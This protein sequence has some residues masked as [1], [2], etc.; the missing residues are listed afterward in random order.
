ML[1]DISIRN[2]ALLTDSLIRK[3]HK[4]HVKIYITL[5]CKNIWQECFTNNSIKH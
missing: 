4:N 1:V 2:D 5:F 3:R